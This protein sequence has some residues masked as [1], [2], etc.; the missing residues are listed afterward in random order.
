MLMRKAK[1]EKARA[2]ATNRL[3]REGLMMQLERVQASHQKA[4]VLLGK[5]TRRSPCNL[6][7]W[8]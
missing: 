4:Q 2:R 5:Q 3:Q 6:V 8:R 1:E 7:M